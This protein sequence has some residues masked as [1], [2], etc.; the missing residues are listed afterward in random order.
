[1]ARERGFER[2]GN[3]GF[4]Q[5]GGHQSVELA[6]FYSGAGSTQAVQSGLAPFF[7]ELSKFHF[8]FP[9]PGV[10]EA[11]FAFWN[12]IAR[13]D[14]HVGNLAH[15]RRIAVVGQH[16]GRAEEVELR[17]LPNFRL[18]QGLEHDF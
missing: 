17:H 18:R 2:A 8:Y 14:R 3:V 16:L 5:G 4:A 15:L 9:I 6:R 11:D 10:H 1:M 12:G 7:V 13:S